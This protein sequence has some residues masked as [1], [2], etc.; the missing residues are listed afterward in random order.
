MAVVATFRG[1]VTALANSRDCTPPRVRGCSSIVAA[2][3]IQYSNITTISLHG[4]RDDRS[5][6]LKPYSSLKWPPLAIKI[7]ASFHDV[8]FIKH[9]EAVPILLVRRRAG[10]ARTLQH[11]SNFSRFII[12][13]F[14]SINKESWRQ[15]Y[16]SGRKCI[17]TFKWKCSICLY[18]DLGARVCFVHKI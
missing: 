3:I 10:E 8:T 18:Y 9:I 17:F 2:V 16:V 4:R 11:Y 5:M 1:Y 6:V 7:I 12:L 15:I 13:I 14:L